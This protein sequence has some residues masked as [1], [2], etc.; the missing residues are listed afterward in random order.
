M[1]REQIEPIIR[2]QMEN[3]WFVAGKDG[4]GMFITDAVD[5]TIKAISTEI[6]KIENPYMCDG[7]EMAK[8]D[9]WKALGIEYEHQAFEECRQKVLDLLKE[10]K[11]E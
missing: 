4:I 11:N 3:V 2:E 10:E 6:Q 9:P 1:I 5:G 7:V 8:T